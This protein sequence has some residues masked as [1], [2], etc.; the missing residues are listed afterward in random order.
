VG[1]VEGGW[2][3]HPG[4]VDRPAKLPPAKSGSLIGVGA[5]C[6]L[7]PQPLDDSRSMSFAVGEFVALADGRRV[8]LHEERGFTVGLR[9]TSGTDPGNIQDHETA[10]SIIRNVLNVVLPDDDDPAEDHPWSWLA[11]LAQA[12]G[13]D[14]TAEDL[15]GLPYGVILTDRV[16]RWLAS[17]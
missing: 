12:R 9:S 11:E 4:A 1:G 10:D 3:A 6:D 5:I 16:T 7:R 2:N 8:I 14:V 13:L 17:D 15:R